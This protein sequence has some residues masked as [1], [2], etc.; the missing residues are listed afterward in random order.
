M[1]K[2]KPGQLL[3]IH[4]GL[5]KRSGYPADGKRNTILH[6]LSRV[7]VATYTFVSPWRAGVVCVGVVVV[8][9]VVAVF[10]VGSV[11]VF[12]VGSVGVVVVLV[13]VVVVV[14]VVVVSG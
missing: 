4:I 12:L 6:P 10:V 11:G 14:F 3:Y 1:F 13:V 9:V 8:V 5:Q 2:V 7:S